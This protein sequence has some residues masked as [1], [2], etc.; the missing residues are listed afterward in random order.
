MAGAFSAFTLKLDRD[1]GDQFL[2]DLNFTM[3]PGLTGSLRGLGYC[4]DAGDRRRRD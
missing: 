1:D 4:P 2:G 3:P